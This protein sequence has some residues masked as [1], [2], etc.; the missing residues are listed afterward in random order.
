MENKLLPDSYP[1]FDSP[2][3]EKKVADLKEQNLLYKTLLNAPAIICTL[4]GP[5]HIVVFG[6]GHFRNF[7][8]DK[9]PVGKH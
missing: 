6:N 5:K 8:D 9:D 1:I 2:D 4:K 3:T 7:I